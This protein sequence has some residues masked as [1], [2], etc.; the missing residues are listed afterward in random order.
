[1]QAQMLTIEKRY[2]RK[3]DFK[4]G[5]PGPWCLAGD[6]NSIVSANERK[7]GAEFNIRASNAFLDCIKGCILIDMGFTGPPF[8]WCRGQLKERLD[9]VLCNSEW[10]SLFPSS[11]VTHVPLP[12]S[13]HCGLWLRVDNGNGRPRTNYFKFLGAWLDHPVFDSQVKHS[14]CSSNSSDVNMKRLTANLK[15]WNKEI[16]GHI[17]KRKNR[18]LSILEGINKVLMAG[19]NSRLSNLKE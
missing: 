7:G 17:F 19:P 4:A 15:S 12:S 3:W 6:F 1:M 10:Q 11:S 14:W 2:G 16:F 13:D 9:R 8:T 5:N 18:I